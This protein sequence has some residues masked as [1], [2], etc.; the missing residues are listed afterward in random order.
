MAGGLVIAAYQGLPGAYSESALRH[1][2]GSR[3]RPLPCALSEQVFEAVLKRKAGFGILPVENTIAGNVAVNADLFLKKNVFVIGECY[4][5]IDHCL[6]APAKTTLQDVETVYSHPVALAQC[7]DFIESRK[8]RAIPEYDT[9]GAAQI[10][11][12]RSHIGEAAI[13]SRDC[14]KAYGLSILK[15]NIQS[16]R[17]NITRFLIFTR[18][19]KVPAGL[20]MRK[21]SLV[22]STQHRPGALLS[23]L[24]RFAEHKINLTRLESRP[25]PENPFEYV[26]FV[27]FLGGLDDP[28]VKRTLAE[29]RKDAHMVKVI[30]SYPLGGR[31]A[32]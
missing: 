9:A 6:L 10:V 18:T 2:F 21:T 17:E 11:A 27:D 26:F 3:A 28:A 1:F 25:I 24:Q 30:G 5:R 7:R 4:L 15:E 8:L 31:P 14:A 22:F 32:S 16:F 20:K 12:Q 19:D 23:C 13:A 29:I